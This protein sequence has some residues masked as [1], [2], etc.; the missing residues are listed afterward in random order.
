MI[1]YRI[2][3]EDDKAGVQQVELLVRVQQV[4]IFATLVVRFQHIEKIG[5]VKILFPDLFLTEQ[6]RVI[7]GEIV[8]KTVERGYNT[9]V[10]L[11][12]LDKE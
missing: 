11:D 7:G 2:N 8:V 10:R 5:Q 9:I 1:L 6:S 4:V 12:T 3:L